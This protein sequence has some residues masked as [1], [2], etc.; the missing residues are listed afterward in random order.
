MGSVNLILLMKSFNNK[1]LLTMDVKSLKVKTRNRK[2]D[3]FRDLIWSASREFS[4]TAGL[5]LYIIFM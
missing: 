5:L 3:K 1:H 4:S 2:L